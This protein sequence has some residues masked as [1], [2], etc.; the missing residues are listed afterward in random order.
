MKTSTVLKRALRLLDGGRRWIK[1]HYEG[2]KDGVRAKCYCAEGAVLKVAQKNPLVWS[3]P[4]GILLGI[5]GKHVHIWNDDHHRRW[6]HVEAA[7]K[8]AIKLAEKEERR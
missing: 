5:V 2:R 7:F 1:G 8:R 4:M 3:R 6:S